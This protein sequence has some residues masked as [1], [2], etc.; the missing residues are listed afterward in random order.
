M[1]KDTSG[2]PPKHPE[3]DKSHPNTTMLKVNPTSF[4]LNSL[5]L[6]TD[7]DLLK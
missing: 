3:Q 6:A 1:I 5:M 2:T 7:L 4:N